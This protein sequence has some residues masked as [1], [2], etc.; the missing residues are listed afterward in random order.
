MPL[1]YFGFKPKTRGATKLVVH[2]PAGDLEPVEPS[3]IKVFANAYFSPPFA[4]LSK[5]LGLMVAIFTFPATFFVH[6]SA[7]GLVAR[8]AV[9]NVLPFVTPGLAVIV[10]RG[11]VL[12]NDA[13]QELER[14]GFTSMVMAGR[15]MWTKENGTRDDY[16]FASM[17]RDTDTKGVTPGRYLSIDSF[18]QFL[19]V[20]SL[21]TRI[22]EA[23]H[24]LTL[25]GAP[26]AVAIQKKN[27]DVKGMK[28]ACDTDLTEEMEATG[29]PS[30]EFV[31][32]EAYELSTKS[33]TMVCSTLKVAGSSL[34]ISPLNSGVLI[35]P[36]ERPSGVLHIGDN[37]VGIKSHGL[38]FKF[39]HQLASPDITL[40]GD[41]IGRYFLKALGDT[42]DEQIEALLA[43]KSG[44]SSLALTRVGDELVH[45]MKCIEIAVDC[46][47]GCVPIF[48]GSRY[49]GALV[50]GGPGA[51]VFINGESFP[52]ESAIDLKQQYL[53]M[54]EHQTNL[55]AILGLLGSA[56]VLED[57][58]VLSDMVQLREMCLSA[59]VSQSSKDEII[60]RAAHLDFGDSSWVIN[61]ANLKRCFN[62]MTNLS[63]LK[64]TDPIGR[65]ALF[66][67]DPVL[68]AL[69]CFGEDSCPSWDI[70]NGTRCSLK[71]AN[72]PVPL[73]DN[74]KKGGP[75]VISDAT[76]VMV[77]RK[78][79]LVSG[80]SE[81]RDMADSG[82]YRSSSSSLAK[83]VGHRVFTREKMAEFWL[84]MR[85]AVRTVNPK[86][87][88]EDSEDGNPKRLR[89]SS[90]MEEAG[91]SKKRRLDV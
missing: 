50:G 14:R 33:I 17:L 31:K 65:L 43:I 25:E 48:S 47:A 35:P 57:G 88:F 63:A 52:F 8:S 61:P 24:Y 67:T 27:S 34:G 5:C 62:L 51:T 77:I 30:F 15:T 91:S 26:Y 20:R 73:V 37:G 38:L 45:L 44:L 84:N 41:I 90:M 13:S 36:L 3:R 4:L 54:S 76:W 87:A 28:N 40:I 23:F 83:S 71:K 19:I 39:N 56:A 68:V 69:S 42:M 75:G 12:S 49:E 1:I 64:H 55:T 18:R 29:P 6:T 58:E 89:E 74:R 70:P 2:T 21:V 85:E 81:F 46:N 86:F 10:S 53:V 82:E 59:F 80:V 16:L 7:E 66:S 78:T 60:R 32:R 72:P 79:D 9:D 22:C 11:K